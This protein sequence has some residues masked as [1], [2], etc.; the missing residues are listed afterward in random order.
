MSKSSTSKTLVWIL[1]ALLIF[2]LGGFGITN[3]GGSATSVGSVGDKE[4]DINAYARALQN[5]LRAVEAQTGQSLSFADARAMGLDQIVLGNLVTTRALDAETDR[6]GISLGDERLAQ[7]LRAISAFKSPDGQFDR[8]AYKFALEQINMTEAEFE[9]SMREES[10][11][12][13]LQTAIVSGL[14]MPVSYGEVILNFVGE[15]RDVTLARL[16]ADDLAYPVAT[17]TEDQLEAYYNANIEDFT[18]PA[19]REIT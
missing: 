17:P 12:A 1:M 5:E 18:R 19:M 10:A 15:E 4:I 3:L 9:T 16:E 8:E 2:G 7:E 13:L 11:R 6:L 14:S